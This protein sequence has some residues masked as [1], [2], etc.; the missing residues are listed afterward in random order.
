MGFKFQRDCSLVTEFLAS[1]W[2]ALGLSP[3]V[4]IWEPKWPSSSVWQRALE[5]VEEHRSLM[6][7]PRK[8]ASIHHF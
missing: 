8:I 5:K 4:Q 1:T 6:N 3:A 7:T 2:E